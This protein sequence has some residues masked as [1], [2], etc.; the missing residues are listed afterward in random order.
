MR[1]LL[2]RALPQNF[3]SFMYLFCETNQQPAPARLL[4]SFRR[5]Y[6]SLLAVRG[7]GVAGGGTGAGFASS[8]VAVAH[9][10]PS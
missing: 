7:D 2:Q 1:A 8:P 6:S 5:N 9:A 10:N 3:P 4:F